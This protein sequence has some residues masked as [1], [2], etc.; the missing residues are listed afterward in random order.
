LVVREDGSCP[1]C[2]VLILGHFIYEFYMEAAYAPQ[3]EEQDADDEGPSPTPQAL[4]K[5]SRR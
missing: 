1:K 4:P 5:T 2:G 3:V